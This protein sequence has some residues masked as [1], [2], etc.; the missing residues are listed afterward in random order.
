VSQVSDATASVYAVRHCTD[1]TCR[2]CRARGRWMRRKA[3]RSRKNPNRR[4]H[5]RKR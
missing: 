3:W 5:G 4:N 1:I 2:K